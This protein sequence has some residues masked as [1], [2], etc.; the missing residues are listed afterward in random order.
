MT[1]VCIFDLD[2]V[3]CHTDEY[4][5]LAWRRLCD[6]LGLMFD[7]KLNERLRGVSRRESLE[8]ILR[9]ND[10]EFPERQMLEFM[11]RKNQW[12]G[13]YLLRM[14]PA[15]L[16]EDVRPTLHSLRSMGLRL[17]I[18]SSSRNARLILD[19][20]GIAGLFDTIV[21]GTMI[22]RSKPDPEVFLKAASLVG[23]SP[24]GC[25]VVEDAL[26]GIHAA[27]RARIP[28]I[29]YRLHDPELDVAI[30]H[31]ETFRDILRIMGV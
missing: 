24:T 6:D 14:S 23:A 30:P 5:Y 27:Q 19:R 9:H 26:S 28:C 4:H 13:E 12:Y 18:G 21:D 3:I 16:E 11:D 8:I 25:V 17:A 7:R 10:V 15:D 2:G 20:L 31:A 22:L 29:A 1:G